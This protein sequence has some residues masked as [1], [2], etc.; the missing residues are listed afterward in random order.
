MVNPDSHNFI[1]ILQSESFW[2]AVA[3]F[4]FIGLSFSKFKELLIKSL[5]NRIA[6]VKKKIEEIKKIKEDAENNLLQS[7]NNLE[8]IIKEKEKKINLSKEESII[9]KKKL[10]KEE[11]NYKERLKKKIKD[12]I[13]QSK[14]QTIEEVQKIILKISVKSIMEFLKSQKNINENNLI[15]KS[16]EELIK[17]KNKI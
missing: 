16:I 17:K 14:K 1:N 11:I 7:K 5:D 3:F 6:N 2:V 9:L 13:E 15:A 10:L 8:N 12:K 4:I